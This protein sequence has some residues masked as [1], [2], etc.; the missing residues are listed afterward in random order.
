L[1]NKKV[2]WIVVLL[3]AALV[4]VLSGCSTSEED[5]ALFAVEEELPL[6]VAQFDPTKVE[7]EEPTEVVEPEPTA[8]EEQ[9]EAEAT[10][11]VAEEPVVEEIDHCLECHTDKET[12]IDT[13]DPVEEAESENE[14]AG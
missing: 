13:A 11:E 1:K 9:E 8:V 3:L 4:L 5:Q 10:E 14:G 2:F 12:L 7:E 6:P